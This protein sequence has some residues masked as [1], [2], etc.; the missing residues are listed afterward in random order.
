MLK[1]ELQ[2]YIT[3]RICEEL[4]GAKI[5]VYKNKLGL[6]LKFSGILIRIEG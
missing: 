4:I 5:K 6:E 1:S 3:L 2:V